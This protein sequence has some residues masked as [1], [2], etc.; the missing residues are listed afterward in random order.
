[1]NKKVEHDISIFP[2]TTP[3]SHLSQTMIC[4]EEIDPKFLKEYVSCRLI[5]LDKG[6]D[7]E[8]N[9]GVRPIGIGEVFR[10]IVGKA[11]MALLKNDIQDAAGPLQTCTGLRSGIEASI[12][13]SK[14]VWDEDETEAIIQVD[15]DNFLIA[16][17]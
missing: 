6:V 9:P 8:G 7:K 2:T 14:R 17:F 11:V 16:S 5:P 10:R 15:A 1:M 13:F 12:H 3:P 4:T